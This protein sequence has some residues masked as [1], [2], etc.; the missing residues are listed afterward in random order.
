[1]NISKTVVNGVISVGGC[2]HFGLSRQK[3]LH[4]YVIVSELNEKEI[5]SIKNNIKNLSKLK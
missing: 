4:E 1:M 5:D 2:S 3:M